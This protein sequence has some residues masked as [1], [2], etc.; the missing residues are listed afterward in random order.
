[1]SYVCYISERR[2]VNNIEICNNNYE[3][4]FY[5]GEVS[6]SVNVN[7]WSYFFHHYGRMSTDRRMRTHESLVYLMT[8][9]AIIIGKPREE[10]AKYMK[11]KCI[12]NK[13]EFQ[14]RDSI[15]SESWKYCKCK[16]NHCK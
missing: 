12:N 11:A 3:L 7:I 9:N 14:W 2:K 10:Q 8:C 15:T 16:I 6:A 4:E 5:R 13:Y 1:L